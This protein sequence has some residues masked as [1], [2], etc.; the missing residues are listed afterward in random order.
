MILFLW[1][2]VKNFGVLNDEIKGFEGPTLFVNRLNQIYYKSFKKVSKSTHKLKSLQQ[3][4]R[5][6]RT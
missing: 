1:T 5:A 3:I 6:G 4:L 2:D